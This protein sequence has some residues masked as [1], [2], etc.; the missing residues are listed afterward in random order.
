MPAFPKRL[1]QHR[2]RSGRQ[3]LTGDDRARRDAA[4]APHMAVS[5][6]LPSYSVFSSGGS[7]SAFEAQPQKSHECHCRKARGFPHVLKRSRAPCQILRYVTAASLGDQAAS[8]PLFKI[9]GEHSCHVTND[10]SSRH[11]AAAAAQILVRLKQ[12]VGDNLP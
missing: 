12:R 8:Q 9:A 4:R 2:P 1:D 5:V 7:A 11:R 6:R 3:A 10:L